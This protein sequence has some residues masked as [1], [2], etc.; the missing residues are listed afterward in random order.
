MR[1]FTEWFD[2]LSTGASADGQRLAG[3]ASDG[4]TLTLDELL[5]LRLNVGRRLKSHRKRVSAVRSASQRSRSLGRGLDFSEVRS[6]QPGDDV[7][8]IDWNVT[9]RTNQVHTKLFEEEKERPVFVVVDFSRSMLFG[10]RTALKSVGAA[11]L[12]AQLA[13]IASAS[14]ERVGGIVFNKSRHIEVKPAGSSRGVLRLLHAL[15]DVHS[16][17][18]DSM[19]SSDL[20]EGRGFSDALQRLRKIAHPGCRVFLLSDFAGLSASDEHIFRWLQIH[21]EF[22]PVRII[23]TLETRL[24]GSGSYPVTDG[25][26]RF[27]FDARDQQ[28][29]RAHRQ[30]FVERGNRLSALCGGASLSGYCAELPVAAAAY[31]VLSRNN[32]A[33]NILAD[34]FSAE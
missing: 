13:W 21:T 27:R 31:D 9:A 14:S 24:P 23:D 1:T 32:P 15:V 16:G 29:Q 2:G 7:R 30:M 20:I 33:A 5:A 3:H 34:E 8:M 17:S 19:K 28:V 4:V 18:I 26:A 11:R 22:F 6:Y 12:G 10:T 25:A